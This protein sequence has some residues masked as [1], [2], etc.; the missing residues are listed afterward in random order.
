MKGKRDL[1]V[2]KHP[3]AE[4]FGFASDD[5]SGNA[6]RHRKCRLCPFNNKIPNCTKDKA[7]APLGICSI[8]HEEEIVITCPIRFRQ[9]WSIAEDAARF[10][11][12]RM[13]IGRRCRKFASKMPRVV[14]RETCWKPTLQLTC[15]ETQNKLAYFIERQWFWLNG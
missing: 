9:N 5:M 8:F 2:S 11:S 10:F 14:R 6:A 12:D 13:P 1:A 15:S 4:V 7:Q 3:L